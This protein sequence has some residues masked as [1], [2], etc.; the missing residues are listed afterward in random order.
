MDVPTLIFWFGLPFGQGAAVCVQF[1]FIFHAV[2][3]NPALIFQPA[4]VFLQ[5]D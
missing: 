1:E 5:L 2:I 3:F 4:V